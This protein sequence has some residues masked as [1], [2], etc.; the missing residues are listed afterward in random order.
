MAR[1]SRTSGT[2]Q[3]AP[4]KAPQKAPP[5]ALADYAR[6]RDFRNT[7][8]PGAE[9]GDALPRGALRFVVQK[10]WASRLH[11]DFRLEIDG[12]MKSWA[13]PK[14]PSFD[15]RDKRMAVQVE[16]HPVAYNRFEGP[17]SRAAVRRGPRHHLGQGLLGAA[18]G[19]GP[20]VAGGQAQVRTAR[21]QAP[22]PVDAGAH[23]R[24]GQRAPAAVAAH[25]GARRPGARCRRVQRGGRPAG[26]REVAAR[27]A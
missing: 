11:Y 9:P 19:P 25:Q 5:D 22:G 27:P 14:G 15:P 17:D 6:K 26:Q 12:T 20:R 2:A 10:H 3:E 18:G 23:A 13:V 21:P 4:R 1:R 24:P 7:P 8:E 16:D